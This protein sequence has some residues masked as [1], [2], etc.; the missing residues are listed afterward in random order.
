VQDGVAEA[1]AIDTAMMNGVNYPFG[2]LAWARAYGFDELCLALDHIAEETG[3]E[4][5]S[6]SQFLRLH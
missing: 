5:Y 1:D 4:M 2:P 3:D 6:P